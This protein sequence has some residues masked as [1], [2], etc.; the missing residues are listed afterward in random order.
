MK[1]N[2]HGYVNDAIHCS[3]VDITRPES[4]PHGHLRG[5]NEYIRE[6]FSPIF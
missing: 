6:F 4:P 2:D 5:S 3:S 1:V